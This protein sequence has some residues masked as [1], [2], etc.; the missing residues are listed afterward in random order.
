MRFGVRRRVAADDRAGAS[1]E[2]EQLEQRRRVARRL[3]GDDSPFERAR[4]DRRE[5]RVDVREKHGLDAKRR[6]V[7]REERV[8]QLRIVGM[9]GR[10]AHPTPS[11]PRAPCDDDER[12]RAGGTAPALVLRARD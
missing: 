1:A 10:D 6:L 9:I 11:M 5:Q 12:R 8:A 7:V 3:V 2:P 4:L